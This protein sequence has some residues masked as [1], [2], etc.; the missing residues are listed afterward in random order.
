MSKNNKQCRVSVRTITLR[1]RRNPQVD[2]GWP[3]E[4]ALLRDWY[5]EKEDDPDL[6]EILWSA[7]LLRYSAKEWLVVKTI[8]NCWEFWLDVPQRALMVHDAIEAERWMLLNVPEQ[9]QRRLAYESAKTIWEAVVRFSDS[10]AHCDLDLEDVLD[11]GE[12]NNFCREDRDQ[13]LLEIETLR[14]GYARSLQRVRRERC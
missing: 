10:R 3:D 6:T 13:C 5:S 12:C 8:W 14:Q 7:I 4:D 1:E 2:D 9:E 11:Q